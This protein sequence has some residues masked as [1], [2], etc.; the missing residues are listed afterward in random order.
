MSGPGRIFNKYPGRARR[1]G[2]LRA[3]ELRAGPLCA[4]CRGAVVWAPRDPAKHGRRPPRYWR[5]RRLPAGGGSDSRAGFLGVPSLWGVVGGKVYFRRQRSSSRTRPPIKLTSPSLPR[6]RSR[7]CDCTAA[8]VKVRGVVRVPGRQN[9]AT[10]A[11]RGSQKNDGAALSES[12]NKKNHNLHHNIG[13]EP[14]PSR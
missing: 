14:S 12:L 11:G 2:S 7:P 13:L 1:P 10:P 3:E 9:A 5:R 6:S 8:R 4:G